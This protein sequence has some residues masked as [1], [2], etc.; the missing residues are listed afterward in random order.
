MEA[1]I[2]T[3]LLDPRTADKLAKLCG[4]FG[5]DHDGERSTAAKKADRLVKECGLTWS[6]VIAQ[7]LTS[8]RSIE[9]EIDFA[10]SHEEVSSDWEWGF[11]NGIRGRQFLTKK[12]RNIVAKIRAH[13][14]AA[15]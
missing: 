11:L 4:L 14:E 12:Q 5:S 15:R 8:P 2:M 1:T 13:A 10:L 6:E 9:E 3:A 7:P